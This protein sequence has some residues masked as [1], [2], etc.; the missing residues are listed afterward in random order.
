MGSAYRPSARPG[1]ADGTGPERLAWVPH[2]DGRAAGTRAAAARL[3]ISW[4]VALGVW[5]LG[6]LLARRLMPSGEAAV[7][8]NELGEVLRG[9]LPCIL[10]GLLATM[11]AGLYHRDGSAGAYRLSG[12]LLVPVLAAPAGVVIGLPMAATGL[13]ALVYVT[14]ALLGAVLGLLV[15]NWFRAGGDHW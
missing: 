1:P 7:P 10:T 6:T 3:L 8:V 14:E 9:H 15:A 4:A 12:I 13:G 5:T 11:A 2:L